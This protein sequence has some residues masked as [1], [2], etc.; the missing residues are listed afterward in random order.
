MSTDEKGNE[1]VR[2]YHNDETWFL[3]K[4]D[5]THLMVANS[6]E[7]IKEGRGA[8]Y[9][10]AQL[11]HRPYYEDVRKWLY[12]KKEIDYKKYYE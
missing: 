12:G 1:I 6:E 3:K 11:N 2:I 7:G 9:H 5:G 8:V 4:I 10:V